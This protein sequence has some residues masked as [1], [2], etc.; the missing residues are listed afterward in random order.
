MSEKHLENFANER[1]LETQ[2]ESEEDNEVTFRFLVNGKIVSWAKTQ[3]YSYLEE[4][5]TAIG[6]KRKGY[7]RKLLSHIEKNAKAH[8]ATTMKAY[9]DPPVKKQ[10]GSLEVWATGLNQLRKMLQ[11]F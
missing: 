1:I 5:L 6:E 3:L 11:D 9:G 2:E 8:G 7:G 10:R 4:I